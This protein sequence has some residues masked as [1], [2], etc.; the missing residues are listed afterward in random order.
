MPFLF[1]DKKAED[2]DRIGIVD[3][4]VDVATLHRRFQAIKDVSV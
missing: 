3:Y 2:I 4:T 1:F